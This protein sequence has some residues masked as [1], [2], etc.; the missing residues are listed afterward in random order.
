M[1]LKLPCNLPIL[2]PTLHFH[3]VQ[4]SFQVNLG[5]ASAKR[6]T[7]KSTQPPM[8]GKRAEERDNLKRRTK[9][10]PRKAI[11]EARAREEERKWKRTRSAD[12]TGSETF[13]TSRTSVTE[14][15]DTLALGAESMN[16]SGVTNDDEITRLSSVVASDLNML[17][18]HAREDADVSQVRAFYLFQHL[19]FSVFLSVC[20]C[21]LCELVVN[22][23]AK[24]IINV[25]V[26][27]LVCVYLSCVFF[28][29]LCLLR[30]LYRT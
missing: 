4:I 1:R 6:N 28:T 9:Y 13:N 19:L 14:D 5:S 23:S 20:C 8:T 30:R 2:L 12:S 16:L 22:S 10:D 24:K 15:D 17:T 27:T 29:N 26:F 11:A 7:S 3:S 21:V 25:F 18:A